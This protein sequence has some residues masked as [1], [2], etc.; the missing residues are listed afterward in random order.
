MWLKIEVMLYQM[1]GGS[2]Q[3]VVFFP[4]MMMYSFLKFSV[5]IAR[6]AG[7]RLTIAYVP[8]LYRTNLEAIDLA[9]PTS[10]YKVPYFTH[11]LCNYHSQ[12]R[13]LTS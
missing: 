8:F 10:N 13:E 9:I 12:K 5:Y 1:K 6:S 2:V 7:T 4:F 3:L 11:D